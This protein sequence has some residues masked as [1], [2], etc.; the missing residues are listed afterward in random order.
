MA[1]DLNLELSNPTYMEQEGRDS[2]LER[3]EQELPEDIA[4]LALTWRREASKERSWRV[5]AQ[6]LSKRLEI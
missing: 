6:D 1:Q 5:D 4:S 2:R 3:R